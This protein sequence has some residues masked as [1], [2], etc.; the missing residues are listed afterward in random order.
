MT[1]T[2]YNNGHCYNSEDSSPCYSAAN[3][4]TD[5]GYGVIGTRRPITSRKTSLAPDYSRNISFTERL[6]WRPLMAG[7][8][9]RGGQYSL[10]GHKPGTPVPFQHYQHPAYEHLTTQPPAHPSLS[11]RNSQHPQRAPHLHGDRSTLP[12]QLP[13]SQ[14]PHY[15]TQADTEQSMEMTHQIAPVLSSS[16]NSV[17]VSFIY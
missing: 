3:S 8:A 11:S 12:Y 15:R 9:P 17:M 7:A 16:E 14:M 4:P 10:F 13:H 1:K 5:E 2:T 6:D